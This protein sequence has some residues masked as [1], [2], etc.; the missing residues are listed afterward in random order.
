MNK[1]HTLKIREKYLRDIEKGTKTFELRKNDREFQ[2]ND[3]IRF[4]DTKGQNY[5]KSSRY[6]YEITYVLKNVPEY[7]LNED[8][9]ILGLRKF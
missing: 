1:L 4:V 9:C 2:V 3:L 7:G 8:Y 5:P 6:L